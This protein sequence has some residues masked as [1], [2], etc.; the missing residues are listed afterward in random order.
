M[1]IVLDGIDGSGK[2]TQYKITSEKLN[3]L[4]IEHKT[5]SFPDYNEKSSTL[6]TMYLKG[7]IADNP[8]EVN[9]F[10]ASSFYAADRYISFKKH[11]ER[12]YISGK[13][14]LASR[15]TTSNILHQMPKLP[16]NQWEDYINWLEDYEYNKL[17]LPKPDLV[18]LL[19]MP[20][21]SALNL[22]N[23]RGENT[24]LHENR[25]YL[26]RCHNVIDFLKGRENFEIITCGDNNKIFDTESI[27]IQIMV[28]IKKLLKI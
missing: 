26:E 14:I 5:V 20:V 9:A 8:D 6:I 10:A 27:N 21:N 16:I 1:L 3:Q 15:Y 2:S 22:I 18:I 19:D 23:A 13:L 17:R 24:D 12:E 11:F 7:E 28:Q 4:G 25:A